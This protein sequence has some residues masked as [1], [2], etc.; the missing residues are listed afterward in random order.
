[1][2]SEKESELLQGPKDSKESSISE[3]SDNVNLSDLETEI[4]ERRETVEN[5]KTD[6]AD[7]QKELSEK[8]AK[9]E[10][11]RSDRSKALGRTTIV[12][13]ILGMSLIVVFYVLGKNRKKK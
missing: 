3:L 13:I 7:Q 5:L 6:L 2:L 8:K 9:I 11:K 10:Q 4:K 1:V 12:L